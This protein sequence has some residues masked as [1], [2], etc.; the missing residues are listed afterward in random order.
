MRRTQRQHQ[1][2]QASGAF[3]GADGV[4]PCKHN[5]VF[6]KACVQ[7][8]RQLQRLCNPIAVC[9]PPNSPLGLVDFRLA[10]GD[11]VVQR[12]LGNG[13]FTRVIG[14]VGQHRPIA[15][16]NSA[17]GGPGRLQRPHGQQQI[18]FFQVHG[19]HAHRIRAGQAFGAQLFKDHHRLVRAA[20]A[21]EQP[22]L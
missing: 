21:I 20:S 6:G 19:G 10:V 14:D 2:G 22:R 13:A 1:I 5:F 7:I 3:L 18:A 8:G 16:V 4:Q 11:H 15:L 12:L 17:L 9:A